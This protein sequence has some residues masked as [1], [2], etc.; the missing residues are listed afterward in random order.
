M[1]KI[2]KRSPKLQK[3]LR[4]KPPLYIRMGTV[5]ITL[6]LSLLLFMCF[7]RSSYNLF[8]LS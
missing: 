4:Q 3:L 6:F 7:L 5:I 2:E 1:D 8:C